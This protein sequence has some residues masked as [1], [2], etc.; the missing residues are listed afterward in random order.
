MK[1]SYVPVLL[2][3][4]VSLVLVS[5]A[6]II[7]TGSSSTPTGGSS[8]TISLASPEIEAAIAMQGGFTQFPQVTIITD[9]YAVTNA[10][11]TLTSVGLTMPVTY[12]YSI[13]GGGYYDAYYTTGY[14]WAYTANQPYTMTVAMNGAVH[15][16]TVTAV[17]NINFN[18]GASGVTISW[19][20][21]GN[22]NIAS[23]FGPSSYTFGPSINS[24]Y[25]ISEVSLSGHTSGNYTIGMT[26]EKMVTSAFSGAYAGSFFS[27]SD[28]ETTTY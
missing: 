25:V 2:F 4:A 10:G 1:R 23:A 26:A 3:V 20:G 6:S 7:P 27:A 19:A 14:S 8:G 22:E 5:C 17:G 9:S 21:G 12:S 24:P 13:S 16:A 11:V 28:Q 18:T 15:K